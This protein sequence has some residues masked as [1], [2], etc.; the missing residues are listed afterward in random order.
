MAI[1]RLLCQIVMVCY[2][3]LFFKTYFTVLTHNGFKDTINGIGIDWDGSDTTINPKHYECV[4]KAITIN[5]PRVV[6]ELCKTPPLVSL[7][8]C[9]MMICKI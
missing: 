6:R 9:F 3:I 4:D 8:L 5:D 2:F 1:V 7:L